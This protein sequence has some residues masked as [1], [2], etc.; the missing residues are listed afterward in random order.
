MRGEWSW[1]SSS[2]LVWDLLSRGED[3]PKI[4]ATEGALYTRAA[5]SL[6]TRFTIES[7]SSKSNYDIDV[8]AAACITIRSNNNDILITN[9]I[10]SISIVPPL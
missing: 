8:R 7:C 5:A 6:G 2:S 4:A 9:L 3:P 10:L 1:S